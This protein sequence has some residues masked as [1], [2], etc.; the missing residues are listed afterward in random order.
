MAFVPLLESVPNARPFRGNLRH[1]MPSDLAVTAE[2]LTPVAGLRFL[3]TEDWR[4]PMFST[5]PY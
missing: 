5:E 1:G 3:I 4:Y 2:V